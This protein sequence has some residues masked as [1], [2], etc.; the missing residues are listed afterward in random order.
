MVEYS[1]QLDA[2]FGSLADSTRRDILCRVAERELSVSEIAAAYKLSLAAISKH[3]KILE[4]ARLV[5]KR[6]RGKQQLVQLSPQAIKSAQ[7]Y[8]DHYE[9]IWNL[10]FDALELLLRH[11]ERH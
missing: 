11:E 4:A 7:G 9:T 6:R 2:T 5:S 1:L 8:L 3:L 10:R